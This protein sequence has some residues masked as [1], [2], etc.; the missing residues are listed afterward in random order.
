MTTNIYILKLQGGRYYVGKTD[1]VMK[2]YQEHLNRSGSSWTRKYKP[3]AIEKTIPN[4][5]PFDEDKWVKIYMDKH[6]IDKVRGGAY[7]QTDLPEFQ[8]EALKSELWGTKDKCINC[9]RTG[10]WAKDCYAKKDI[11]GKSFEEK[12]SKESSEEETTICGDC[13]KEFS[14]EYAFERHTCKSKKKGVC[15]RCGRAGHYSPDCYART[16]KDGYDLDSD[17]D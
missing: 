13:E 3:I 15:Y 5:S 9:G 4:A 17:E 12:S 16:H 8:E 7:V 14:S 1:N 6:G 11:T 10:H 2:R